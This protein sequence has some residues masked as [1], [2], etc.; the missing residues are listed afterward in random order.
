[1]VLYLSSI[2]KEQSIWL[3]NPYHIQLPFVSLS[4]YVHQV[5]FFIY[6]EKPRN[7]DKANNI[8]E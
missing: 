1:M 4:I 8:K 3:S 2:E 5:P 6:S 7:N